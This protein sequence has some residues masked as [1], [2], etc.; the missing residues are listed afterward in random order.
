[1][2]SGWKSAPVLVFA[3]AMK[4]SHV[5]ALDANATAFVKSSVPS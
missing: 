4:P 3:L 1:M 5:P 2:E